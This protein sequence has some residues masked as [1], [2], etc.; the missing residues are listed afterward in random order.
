MALVVQQLQGCQGQQQQKRR[1][2]KSFEF[3]D[4][5]DDFLS[6]S[7]NVKP[8]FVKET[9]VQAKTRDIPTNSYYENTAQA[10]NTDP[11]REV[12]AKG[13]SR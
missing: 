2:Q 7:D 8:R 3:C 5:I 4:D 11:T 13:D 1:D 9:N 10:S 12:V 6:E